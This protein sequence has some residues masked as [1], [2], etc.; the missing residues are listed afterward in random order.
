MEN[1]KPKVVFFQR[2]PRTV[3]NYS[4]EFI[5]DDV[6]NRLQS[7]I[8]AT[9]IYSKYE[10]SGL[11]KRLYNVFQTWN[12]QK[13]V[14]HVTGD[15]SYIGFFLNKKK[16]IHTIL[17]CV[18]LQKATGLKFKILKYFWLTVP[19]KR[20]TFI[21]AISTATKNEILKYQPCNPDKIVVIP[22]AISNAFV[23]IQKDFNSTK[24]VILQL[25]TA[26]NKNIMHL[27]EAVKSINCH[28]NIIGV[29][30]DELINYMQAN[31]ISYTYEHGLTNDE[32]RDRYQQ[33]DILSLISTYEGF[34]MPILE[35]QATGRAVI[36]ANVFSMPEVGGNACHYVDPYNVKEI[37]IN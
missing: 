18:F 11:F 4:V 32:I 20:S 3:G 8:E 27:L 12:N 10:S 31:N 16:T 34:G 35:A 30:H 28:I 37:E 5:F 6:R 26:P 21:T 9:L 29:K 23:P 2:K 22:V 15:V 33:C 13:Q 7:K 19:V 1:K 25:G 17:D 14:N 24:P 36:T